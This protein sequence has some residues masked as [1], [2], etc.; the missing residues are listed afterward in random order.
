M[1]SCRCLLPT[2]FSVFSLFKHKHKSNSKGARFEFYKKQ[3]LISGATVE[4]GSGGKV[5]S[6]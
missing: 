3:P 5:S 2:G 4:K 1:T 6:L